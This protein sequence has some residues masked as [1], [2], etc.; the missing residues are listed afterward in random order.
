MI[1][2]HSSLERGILSPC[3]LSVLFTA[4]TWTNAFEN[5]TNEL[6]DSEPLWKTRSG[7]VQRFPNV[8]YDKRG[9]PTVITDPNLR[10]GIL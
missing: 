8:G 5:D 7:V 6:L 2:S 1:S 3:P 4:F 9:P 10:A